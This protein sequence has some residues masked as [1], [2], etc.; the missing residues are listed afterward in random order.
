M[1]HKW[2]KSTFPTDFY[3]IELPGRLLTLLFIY[4]GQSIGPRLNR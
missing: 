4:I 1:M 3:V 2:A